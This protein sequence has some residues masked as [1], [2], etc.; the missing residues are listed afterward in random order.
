MGTLPNSGSIWG[1][2]VA[3]RFGE[4]GAVPS[5]SPPEIFGVEEQPSSSPDVTASVAASGC[6]RGAGEETSVRPLPARLAVSPRFHLR[7]SPAAPR[8]LPAAPTGCV[9][10][11]PSLSSPV[12]LSPFSPQ[13]FWPLGTGVARG[14]LAAFDAAWM[15][16]RWVAGTPPLEVLAER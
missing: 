15:V 14:F 16:R 11:A 6:S 3:G 4:D 13:P 10:P 9:A 5:A 1:C 7:P 8:L 2:P 12:P